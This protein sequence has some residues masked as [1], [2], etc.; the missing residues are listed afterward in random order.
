M[1]FEEFEQEYLT[2]ILNKKPDFI[3][4][5]QALFNYLYDVHPNLADEIRGTIIDPFHIDRNIPKTLSYINN[6]WND[7]Q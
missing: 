1:T 7:K 5:G 2:N 3:R 4:K 6:H